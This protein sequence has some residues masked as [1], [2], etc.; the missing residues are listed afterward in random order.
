MPALYGDC[1]RGSL[2]G[3]CPLVRILRRRVLA[4][5]V[6]AGEADVNQPAPSG[7]RVGA[8]IL[9]AG[10]SS[11]MAGV[12]KLLL[13]LHGRPLITYALEA[14]QECAAVDDIAVVL[15]AGNAP[16]I[17]SLLAQFSKVGHAVRG[18]E[19]RQD[20]VRA[21]LESL[22]ACDWVVVHDGA[23]P[24]VTAEM[25]ERGLE[26]ARPVGAAA[27]AMPV[28][29]TLKAAR[30]DGAV[31]RTVSRSGLWAVQTPQ[32]FR[33]DLLAMAHE[34]VTEDVTDDCAMLEQIGRPV[35]LYEGSRLNIKVTTPEDS[36]IAGALLR[37]R[38]RSRAK[39]SR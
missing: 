38:A 26:V 24:L 12:D 27:A 11:R 25:I 5:T 6:H 31:L 33:W 39:G 3:M 7:E 14:F 23:R 22:G 20:S 30:E 1:T 34:R 32:V 8:I 19:R 21:G 2:L 13:P 35:Q 17:L 16:A 28:V 36:V 15:A 4:A 9:A 18:G 37:L 29:D 10:S